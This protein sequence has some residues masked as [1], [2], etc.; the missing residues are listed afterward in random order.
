MQNKNNVTPLPPPS[1]SLF[2]L[3]SL[4]IGQERNWHLKRREYESHRHCGGHWGAKPPTKKKI[5]IFFCTK[6][7]NFFSNLNE[8]SGIGLIDKKSN[9]RSMQFFY[10]SSYGHFCFK[11]RKFSIHFSRYLDK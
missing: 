6:I 5:E 9:F 7:S 8:R 10:F 4:R 3:F 1:L 2:F 11:K